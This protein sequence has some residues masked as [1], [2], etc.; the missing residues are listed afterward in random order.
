MLLCYI[1][2]LI[3]FITSKLR[4]SIYYLIISTI[5]ISKFFFCFYRDKFSPILPIMSVSSHNFMSELDVY[6]PFSL[7]NLPKLRIATLNVHSVCNKSA[8]ISDHI[9]YNKFDIICITKTCINDGEFSNFCLILT[10][11]K[12]LIV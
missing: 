2:K 8:V 3:I 7:P 1:R 4:C 12:L 9:L 5:T 6:E 11:S 10:S